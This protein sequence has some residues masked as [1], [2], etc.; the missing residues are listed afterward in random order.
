MTTDMSH[1]VCSELYPLM[2]A[3]HTKTIKTTKEEVLP[4]EDSHM[5]ALVPDMLSRGLPGREEAGLM[6]KLPFIQMYL[7][8][9]HR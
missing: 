1:Q 5:P 2:L 9:D 8:P 3:L 4:L 6:T 7:I